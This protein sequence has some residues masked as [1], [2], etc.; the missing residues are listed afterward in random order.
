MKSLC[1]FICMFIYMMVGLFTYSACA[2]KQPVGNF[3]SVECRTICDKTQCT[4]QCVSASGD[5][6][7]K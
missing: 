2:K 3:K 7:K 1:A 4:Q 5:Y 6:Y